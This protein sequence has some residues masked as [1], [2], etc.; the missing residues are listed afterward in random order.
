[1]EFSIY[2]FLYKMIKLNM[3]NH[4]KIYYIIFILFAYESLIIN[5]DI[6]IVKSYYNS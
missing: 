4:S 6:H 2:N 3:I 1:M 5:K